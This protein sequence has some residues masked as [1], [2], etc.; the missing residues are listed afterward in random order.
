MNTPN[1]NGWR[2]HAGSLGALALITGLGYMVGVRPLLAARVEAWELDHSLTEKR[3][4]LDDLR[5]ELATTKN[6]LAVVRRALDAG[7]I[8][9][10][11]SSLLN[12][13]LAKLGIAAETAGVA[14]SEAA[15]GAPE[16]G[17]LLV[18]IPIRISGKGHYPDF[19]A[20]LRALDKDLKDTVVVGFN[21]GGRADMPNEPATFSV[22][23]LW[24]ALRE[25]AASEVREGASPARSRDGG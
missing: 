7:D 13:Q 2:L 4:A 10:V 3:S 17:S 23:L 9:L 1:T 14:V 6:D 8:N 22:D 24:Y 16:E 19:A 5:A 11:G 15:P 20:F 18:R 25:G 12:S 21:L